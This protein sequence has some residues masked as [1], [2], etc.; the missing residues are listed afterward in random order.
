MEII[1]AIAFLLWTFMVFG[2]LLLM[3][4]RLKFLEKVLHEILKR[5]FNME[6][7]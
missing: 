3:V 2:T 1:F 7:K 4:F 6:E 5:M